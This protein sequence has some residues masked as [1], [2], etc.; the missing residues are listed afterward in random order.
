MEPEDALCGCWNTLGPKP[1]FQ[2][3]GSEAE[4]FFSDQAI[5][6]IAISLR[7]SRHNSSLALAGAKQ[8]VRNRGRWRLTRQN[9]VLTL[10]CQVLGWARV[11]RDST[12]TKKRPLS[13]GLFYFRRCIGVPPVGEW[14][15]V[16][17]DAGVRPAGIIGC[18]HG[19]I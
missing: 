12:W 18:W 13:R 9:A 10:K 8:K 16:L 15:S 2:R 19:P 7:I 11:S 5:A 14:P 3:P 1:F 4:E 6:R 17:A